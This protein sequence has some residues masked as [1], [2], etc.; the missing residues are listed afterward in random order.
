LLVF[1][2]LKIMKKTPNFHVKEEKVTLFWINLLLKQKSDFL[3]ILSFGEE[4]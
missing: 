1:D 3:I 2:G 4:K